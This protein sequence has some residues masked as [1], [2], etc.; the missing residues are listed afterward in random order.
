[1]KR[2]DLV[3]LLITSSIFVP[4]MADA[5]RTDRQHVIGIFTAGKAISR[6][7][8]AP[9]VEGLEQ[10]GWVEGTNVAF[11]SRSAEDQLGRLP[12][13][14]SELV[15]L[16]V[17]VIV[18]MGTLAPLALKRATSTIPIVMANAGD[19][20]ATG[21][22]AS[23]A[24]PGGNVTGLSLMAPDLGAKRLGLLRELIPGIV[25]VAILWNGANP[26]PA[27]VYNETRRGA[28]E[29]GIELQSL[30]V[31]T[32]ADLGPAF[33]SAERW[34]AGALITVEDPLTYGYRRQ[35]VHRF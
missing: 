28:S 16:K 9:L 6:Q 24:E 12:E 4:G 29:L 27:Y 30:E 8:L 3:W 22:V 11:E 34:G 33:E 25:R 35:L 10:L 18:A 19:P 2:R 7:E 14:A 15:G 1:M 13:L 23:L 26:Y 17:D 32:P 20:I 5:Q 21:L 31:R